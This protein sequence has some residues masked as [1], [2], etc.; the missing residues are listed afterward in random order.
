MARCRIRGL[1]AV[2]FCLA[3]ASGTGRGP[4][5]VALVFDLAEGCSSERNPNGAW[6]YG[7][8]VGRTLEPSAFRRDGFHERQPAIGF[9]QPSSTP[10]SGHYPYVAC[11][12][13]ANTLLVGERGTRR[14]LAVRAGQAAM[15]ASN[16]GQYS[17]VR[18]TVPVA[19][20][21]KVTARF[22]GI[23]FGLSTTDVHV[24]H[25][26]ASLFAADI[27]GYGGDPALHAVEGPSPVA[28]Y[29]GTV[30]LEAGDTVDFAVGFGNNRTHYFDTT[31][32]FAR[33]ELQ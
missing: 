7:Y 20:R 3:C 6:E 31:G 28:A 9:W 26:G 27:D 4:R 10:G 12:P 5:P 17:V 32:L 14:G 13:S 24:M 23:H 18:F 33:L 1:V 11:N 8:T 21:Y 19:G 16:A 30:K 15:E 22:E 25:G 2:F 29:A